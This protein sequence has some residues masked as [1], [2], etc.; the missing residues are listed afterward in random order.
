MT[1]FGEQL[2][3]CGGSSSSVSSSMSQTGL[4][5]IRKYDTT[6][7]EKGEISRAL[8]LRGF[9]CRCLED[10]GYNQLLIVYILISAPLLP[11]PQVC[12]SHQ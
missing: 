10:I 9:I 1:A 3:V 7:D 4:I 5:L 8:H 11:L 12:S 6:I 2:L